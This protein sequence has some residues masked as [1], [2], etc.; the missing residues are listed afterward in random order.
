MLYLSLSKYTL[1]VDGQGVRTNPKRAVQIGPSRQCGNNNHVILSNDAK[2]CKA[3]MAAGRVVQKDA[4]PKAL[5]EP[6]QIP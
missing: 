6:L 5:E 3:C 1:L 2:A 4:K